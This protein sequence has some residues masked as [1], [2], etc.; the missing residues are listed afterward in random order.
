MATVFAP[1]CEVK[2]KVHTI[3]P[4]RG[5]LMVLSFLFRSLLISRSLGMAKLTYSSLL[6]RDKGCVTVR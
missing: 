6:H 1:G 5:R 4:L 2:V 3:S